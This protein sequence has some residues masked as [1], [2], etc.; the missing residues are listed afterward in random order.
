[1]EKKKKNLTR[2]IKYKASKPCRMGSFRSVAVYVFF[3]YYFPQDICCSHL[4]LSAFAPI[5]TKP[6]S[7][8]LRRKFKEETEEK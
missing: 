8:T 1:M 7:G 5:P 3:S 4:E 2:A 6:K